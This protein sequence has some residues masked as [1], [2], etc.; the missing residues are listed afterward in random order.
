MGMYPGDEI[1]KP[2][3][4]GAQ[5]Q[6]WEHLAAVMWGCLIVVGVLMITGTI[7]S[8]YHFLDDHELVRMEYGFRVGGAS[9]GDTMLALAKNDLWWRFR[10]LYWVERV[11]G[12]YLL[13][14]NLLYWNIYTA[15]QGVCACYL[16]YFMARYTGNGRII[17]ALFVSV[18]ILG[19]QFTPWYRSAN[20]ENTGLL[21]CALTLWLIAFQHYKGKE[22]KTWLN[23][24]IVVSAAACGLIKESFTLFMP[25]FVMAKIWLEYCGVQRDQPGSGTEGGNQKASARI[26]WQCI[27][28]NGFS[29][30]A[31]L[32]AMLVN[33]YCI[34]FVVGVG[35]VSYAGFHEGTALSQ[36][37]RG[38]KDSLLVYLDW[39]TYIGII[40]ILL[41]VMCYKLIDRKYI[42]QYAGF[43]VIG[44]YIMVV[45]LIA[46]A[47]S[48][49]WERYIIPFILGWALVF[50]LLGYRIFERD[51]V[52]RCV[53]IG[54]LAFLLLMEVPKAYLGA[55]SYA[56]DGQQIQQLLQ[57]VL[58]NTAPE[59]QIIGAFSAEELNLATASWLEARGRAKMYSYDSAAET[60]TETVQFAVVNEENGAWEQAQ[61]AV[62][63]SWSVGLI[64]EKMGFMSENEYAVCTYGD[65]SVILRQ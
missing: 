15:V 46:H 45:Q 53:Y 14:S 6:S 1:K 22:R 11:L 54:L 20:Q 23:V 29:C 62:C 16:L 5:I 24:L 26:F 61:A 52:Q 3:G 65:Y 58:E 41:A 7:T 31:I 34:M 63:Y 9:L 59:N 28:S 49:M 44:C 47:S 48:L 4:K 19:A 21:L 43:A 32:A 35:N 38:V 57:C 37:L 17:S 10:P 8:G 27:K 39:Y 2:A 30:G 55:K 13:G 18:V 36:Y 25:V 64:A 50:V 51:K 56:Y 40:C 60:L 12:A 33:L 42:K